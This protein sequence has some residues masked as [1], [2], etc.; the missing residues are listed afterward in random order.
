[1]LE[2]TDYERQSPLWDKIAL[3]CKAQI[4]ASRDRLEHA[5]T[6]EEVIRLQSTISV[7]RAIICNKHTVI[8][9]DPLGF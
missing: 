5:K 9:R 4:E 7:Y 2:L 8:P 6:I 3:E 1:M